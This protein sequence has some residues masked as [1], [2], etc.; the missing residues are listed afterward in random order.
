MA[1]ENFKFLLVQDG[2][3]TKARPGDHGKRNVDKWIKAS[4]GRNDVICSMKHSMKPLY[5]LYLELATG[6]GNFVYVQCIFLFLPVK[7][8]GASNTD[9]SVCFFLKSK[10]T[11][12]S[13]FWLKY[14]SQ[15]QRKSERTTCRFFCWNTFLKNRD[16]CFVEWKP[17]YWNKD[18]YC[19]LQT[20]V[21]TDLQPARYLK[22]RQ[23]VIIIFFS[24]YCKTT[25]LWS[26]RGKHLVQSGFG[27][28]LTFF[29]KKSWATTWIEIYVEKKW[30][31]QICPSRHAITLIT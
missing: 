25:L 28:E 12:W 20:A 24:S 6:T 2:K 16:L 22:V 4:M 31:W 27:L 29:Y 11:T 1:K 10:G 17:I 26:G 14:F 7:I 23:P 19:I 5:L 21:C 18:L 9:Q 8:V 13:C 3:E 15:G 30:K